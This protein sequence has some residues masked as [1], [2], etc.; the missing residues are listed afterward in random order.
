VGNFSGSDVRGSDV[1]GSNGRTA[2]AG[3]QGKQLG[4]RRGRDCAQG[5]ELQKDGAELGVPAQACLE[6]QLVYS[7]VAAGSCGVT[8]GL[9]GFF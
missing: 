3:H 9:P 8:H 6:Q 2:G 1:R 4:G 5:L 7:P